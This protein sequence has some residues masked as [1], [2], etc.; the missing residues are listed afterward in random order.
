MQDP[1]DHIGI[2]RI[3]SYVSYPRKTAWNLSR[4]GVYFTAW[5]TARPYGWRQGLPSASAVANFLAMVSGVK[6]GSCLHGSRMC[7]AVVSTTFR[8]ATTDATGPSGPSSPPL[9]STGARWG[10]SAACAPMWGLQASHNPK[11]VRSILQLNCKSFLE[12]KCG[13]WKM[14]FAPGLKNPKGTSSTPVQNVVQNRQTKAWYKSSSWSRAPVSIVGNTSGSVYTKLWPLCTFKGS[15][16]LWQNLPKT[17]RYH[18]GSPGVLKV[19]L[20]ELKNFLA[21]QSKPWAVWAPQSEAHLG[22]S[23][24]FVI[25]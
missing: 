9:S 3:V 11:L 5:S 14:S 10:H 20:L 7:A 21:S 2:L 8:T 4:F 6:K 16:C 19:V 1:W 12:W 23:K 22:P 24:A 13:V 25:S 15:W 17:W 18:T